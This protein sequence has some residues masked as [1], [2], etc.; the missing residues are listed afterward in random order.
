M[1][2]RGASPGRTTISA[3]ESGAFHH[4]PDW[5]ST[6]D[7]SGDQRGY[8]PSAASLRSCPPSAG[9]RNTPPPSRSDLKAMVLPSGDQAGCVS[10]SGD[11]VICTASPPATG[12]TQI[13]KLPA[14]SDAYAMNR[15]SG[16]NVTSVCR[17]DPNV[18]RVRLRCTGMA[19][20]VVGVCDSRAVHH[21]VP[22]AAASR[23]SAAVPIKRRLRDRTAGT[24]TD[25]LGAGCAAA[26]G[27][28]A[29]LPDRASAWRSS[30]SA[31][32][33]RSRSCTVW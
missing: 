30:R 9:T 32:R 33:S 21:H 29:P 17:P 27:M 1:I 7:P 8:T 23:T 5:S 31:C 10:G 22:A 16:E 18:R 13:S 25:P 24:A 14:R 26:A 4:A 3:I 11:F 12:C 20:P 2:G 15:P 28:T 6:C 19:W